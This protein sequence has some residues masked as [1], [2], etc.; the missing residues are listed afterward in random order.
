M[1]EKVPHELLLTTRQKN[2][3]RSA[4]SNNMAT[5]IKLLKTQISKTTQSCGYLGALL[6]SINESSSFIGKEYI[7]A[8]RSDSSSISN[9]CRNSKENIWFWNNDTNNCFSISAFTRRKKYCTIKKQN[10]KKNLKIYT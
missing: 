10:K 2:K 9:R 4:F 8:I 6:S 5:G 1:G 3:L 7:S